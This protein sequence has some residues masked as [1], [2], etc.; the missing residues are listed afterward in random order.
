MELRYQRLIIA[1]HGCDRETRDHVLLDNVALRRSEN[2]Y[3][4][5]GHGI[6]FWEYGPERA[7][8]WAEEQ[9]A[10]GK[11]KEP[12]VLGAYINLGHCFDL[13]DVRYT[14]VLREAYGE[15][16]EVLMATGKILPQN[17]PRFEGDVDYLARR[18]DCAVINWT[19]ERYNKAAM[20]PVD[21][22][23]GV[24]QEGQPAFPGSFIREKSHIQIAVREASCIVGFFRP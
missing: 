13:L 4:W 14:K 8:E 7:L 2:T 21:T 22:V 10:W 6:Y 18:R 12:A 15:F 19:L 16:E 11:I 9:H 17:T 5:L 1:Y 3:D 20:S 24:F 23:R